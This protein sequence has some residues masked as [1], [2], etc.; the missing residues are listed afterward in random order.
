MLL[1]GASASRAF[2]QPDPATRLY[3]LAGPDEA[4]SRE[5]VAAFAKAMGADAERIDISSRD[6]SDTPSIV[7]DEAASLSLFGAR[8]W[9]LITQASGAGDEWLP[10]ATA[11]LAAE[12]SV[13]PALIIGAG[14]TAKSKLVKLAQDHSHGIAVISYLPDAARAHEL[15][16]EICGP[17]G[18]T[19]SRD[20]ARAMAD[21]CGGNR[22]LI[23]QEAEKL[24]LYLDAA[25]ER[26][27]RAEPA[28]W[29]AIGAETA[30]EDV[31]TIVNQ[32]MGGLVPELPGALDEIAAHGT[33]EIRL[34]R[35]L[36]TR[37]VVLARLRS[38]VDSRAQNSAAAVDAEPSIF[39]KDKPAVK[40]QLARWPAA[41]LARLI[42]RLHQLERDLKAPDNAGLLLL[43]NELLMISLAAARSR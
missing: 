22:A 5:M 37:A 42:G 32:I 17:M 39:W 36:A 19:V 7:A 41:A 28:D 14:M 6:L 4:A 16:P 20:V 3:V 43:R 12:T 21:A 33:S 11:L 2:T 27:K 10:A 15:V 26:P 13:N 30:E 1:K 35:A 24:A 38:Q 40:H 31:G 29:L 8:R 23:A 34:V 25:P 18:L 9:L